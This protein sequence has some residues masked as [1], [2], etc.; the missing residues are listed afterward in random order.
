MRDERRE[1]REGGYESVLRSFCLSIHFVI[2]LCVQ[3]FGFA[4]KNTLMY[5]PWYIISL[6]KTK[7]FYMKQWQSLLLKE[8]RMKT[9]CFFWSKVHASPFQ[10]TRDSLLHEV[11]SLV[12]TLFFKQI[13]DQDS[14]F[15]D[16]FFNLV[17]WL[18][19]SWED[20]QT[21]QCNWH[22]KLCLV[23]MT[24]RTMLLFFFDKLC[25]FVFLLFY[26]SPLLD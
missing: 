1:R 18:I 2:N 25:E 13:Y 10:L 4:E 20:W 8:S 5:K 24:T 21:M 26:R 12:M 14:L 15:D 3:I 22:E 6:A 9:L 19:F 11:V 17:V 16:L 7:Y 23:I